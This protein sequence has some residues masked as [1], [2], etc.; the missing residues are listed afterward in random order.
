MSLFSV[1][2]LSLVAFFYAMDLQIDSFPLYGSTVAMEFYT[3]ENEPMQVRF[4]YE[5]C[6]VAVKGLEAT[7]TFLYPYSDILFIID[8]FFQHQDQAPLTSTSIFIEHSY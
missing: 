8:T 6:P 2:D 5:G 4:V 7:E 3:K 1:H